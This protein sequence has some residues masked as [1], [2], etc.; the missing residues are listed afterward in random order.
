MQHTTKLRKRFFVFFLLFSFF[1][2]NVNDW[3]GDIAIAHIF[4]NF[5][6][7]FSSM[8]FS[9]FLRFFAVNYFFKNCARCWRVVVFGL[10]FFLSV[11]VPITLTTCCKV[12]TPCPVCCVSLYVFCNGQRL[13]PF[14]CWSL[15]ST[16]PLH[17]QT[18]CCNTHMHTQIDL[19]P[20]GKI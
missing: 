18:N 16:C 8:W 10:C 1:L 17:W 14:C 20:N 5:E 15:V 13:L 3:G 2:R 12:C 7:E 6:I 4:R 19:N 9:D 11:C